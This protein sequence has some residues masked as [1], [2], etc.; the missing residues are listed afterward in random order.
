MSS[1]RTASTSTRDKVR[2]LDSERDRGRPDEVA[3]VRATH[4]RA[5]P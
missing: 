1:P 2:C 3:P 5:S 4:V